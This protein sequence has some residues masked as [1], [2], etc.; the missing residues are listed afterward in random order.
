MEGAFFVYERFPT[1]HVLETRT[2]VRAEDLGHSRAS[3]VPSSQEV[4]GV[5]LRLHHQKDKARRAARCWKTR[6][7]LRQSRRR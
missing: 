3:T 6:R 1:D 5:F 4:R 7:N 2:F